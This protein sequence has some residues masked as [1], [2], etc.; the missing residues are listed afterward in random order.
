MT[1]LIKMSFTFHNTNKLNSLPAILAA[2]EAEP[3]PLPLITVGNTCNN[4]H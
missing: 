3:T 1:P 4:K 2:M